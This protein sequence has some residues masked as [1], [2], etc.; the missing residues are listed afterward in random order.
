MN[1]LCILQEAAMGGSHW[2]D[3]SPIIE[4]DFGASAVAVLHTPL[5]YCVFDNGGIIEIFS[6]FGDAMDWLCQRR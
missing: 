4:L 5:G 2:T 3:D 6:D 1:H